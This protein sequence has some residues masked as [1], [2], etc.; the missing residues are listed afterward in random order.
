MDIQELAVII[1]II[2]A[3]NMGTMTPIIYKFKKDVKEDTCKEFE[4][5]K[6]NISEY[7]EKVRD[8]FQDIA[9]RLRL[10]EKNL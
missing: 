5:L 3:I 1:G 8:E 4:K 2:S 9:V 10:L 6:N 7:R